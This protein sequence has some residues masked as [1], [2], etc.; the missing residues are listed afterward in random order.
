MANE[1]Y[2]E[3]LGITNEVVET[4]VLL[5]AGEVD[6]VAGVGRAPVSPLVQN[7]RGGKQSIRTGIDIVPRE[8]GLAIAIRIQ[9]YYGYRL[10]EVA[11]NVR[12]A[13]ADA[14]EGQVGAKVA[15]VDVLIDGVVFA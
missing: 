5:S 9:V 14:I 8:D 12:L 15:S 3:G 2:I 10:T 4:I 1:M 13:I 6:G 11:D 7:R